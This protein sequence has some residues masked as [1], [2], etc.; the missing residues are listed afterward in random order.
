MGHPPLGWH[1]A[2]VSARAGVQP[3]GAHG[4]RSRPNPQ[5]CPHGHHR[6][7]GRIA[8]IYPACKWLLD[9]LGLLPPVIALFGVADLVGGAWT[10]YCLRSD[11]RRTTAS[12]VPVGRG[13]MSPFAHLEDDRHR[14]PQR[15]D[16]SAFGHKRTG[17]LFA[18][19]SDIWTASPQGHRV[20]IRR[21]RARRA[22]RLLRD[23]GKLMD[24]AFKWVRPRTA[25]RA[26]RGQCKLHTPV[27]D[28]SSFSDPI[29]VADLRAP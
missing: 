27:N 6:W 28:V 3:H 16:V 7:R 2:A 5:H 26:C 11:A 21:E 14:E 13:R 25:A 8:S 19:V 9:L 15:R 29:R 1:R 12:P 4:E 22:W 20:S 10:H 18:C 24:N 23:L 17:V